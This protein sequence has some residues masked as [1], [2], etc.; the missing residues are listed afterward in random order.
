MAAK[1][2]AKLGNDWY[3]ISSD[4]YDRIVEFIEKAIRLSGVH[5]SEYAFNHF[6][7]D[8]NKILEAL[9]VTGPP[10]NEA[11][12]KLGPEGPIQ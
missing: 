12:G 4:L 10:K 3:E 2:C 6:N 7:E 11:K 1:K 9:K 5:L 8:G